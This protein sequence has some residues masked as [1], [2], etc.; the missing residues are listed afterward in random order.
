MILATPIAVLFYVLASLAVGFLGRNT[1]VGFAGMF[2][3]SL[4][5]T[6]LFM[7]LALYVSAPRST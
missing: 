4:L 3:L 7:I 5:L 2:V 1:A 6:P